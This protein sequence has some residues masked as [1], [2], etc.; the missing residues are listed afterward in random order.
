M[1]PSRDEWIDALRARYGDELY[2]RIS[3]G[4]V[5]ICGVGGLGSNIALLLARAGVGRF[6]LVDFDNVDL[7][8]IHRQQYKLSQVG[9]QKVEALRDNILEIAPFCD[10]KICNARITLENAR[11][12]LSDVDIV[13]EAFDDAEA[14]AMLTNFVLDEWQDKYLVAASGMA[15]MGDANTIV[16]RKVGK[17]FYLCGDGVSDVQDDIGL[18]SSRVA[19]CAAHQSHAILQILANLSKG[20]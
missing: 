13:C 14:K 11:E 3:R 2:D 6:L 8:N 20:S 17:R 15:G 10:V 19:L 9:I 12:L 4:F 5:A 16:T 7:T 1:T 18:I